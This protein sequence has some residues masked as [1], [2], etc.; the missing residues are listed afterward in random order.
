[1]AERAG[2]ESQVKRNPH[3]D[4]AKVESERVAFDKDGKFSYTQRPNMEWTK[5]SGANNDDW[6]SHTKLEIDPYGPGRQAVDNYKLLIS[7]IVPRPIGFVSTVSKTGVANL[8]PFSYTMIVNHDPPMFCIGIA[9]GAGSL[10]DTCVNVLETGELT[11]NIISESFI[12]AANYTSVDCPPGVSEWDLAGL[13]PAKSSKVKPAHVAESAFS[14]EAKLAHHH[15]WT[16]PASGKQTGML[17]ICEGVNFHVR[18]DAINEE[19]NTIK[20]E[21]L[22]PVGRLGGITY[23]RTVTGFE[24][25][26]PNWAS[27]KSS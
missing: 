8:A 11:I 4:F 5:G 22:M 18:D 13:T 3:A 16:S 15:E 24:I 25:L 26:R 21:V 23:S 12:E 2:F 1:M 17:L 14:I 9:G 7:G 10:K 6:K 20:P 27:E 19:K